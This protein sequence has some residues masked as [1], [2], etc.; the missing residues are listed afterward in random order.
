MPVKIRPCD[1][2]FSSLKKK[3]KNHFSKNLRIYN[4]FT[5][6]YRSIHNVRSFDS[7]EQI[8]RVYDVYVK[9]YVRPAIKTSP[10][11]SSNSSST[12]DPPT[13]SNF[14]DGQ[15]RIIV[16]PIYSACVSIERDRADFASRIYS[17]V[18]VPC[19]LEY[20][21]PL[22]VHHFRKIRFC[23]C[24]LPKI[25]NPMLFSR[26]ECTEFRAISCRGAMTLLPKFPSKSFIRSG[27]SDQK[28]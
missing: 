28:F 15:V 10:Y 4:L 8:N 1:A 14:C 20:L 12:K 17:L 13:G 6:F 16:R 3:R 2:P 18:I 25:P 23:P 27:L 21:L 19:P 11:K 22:L 9:S 24:L 7:F 5:S 26:C